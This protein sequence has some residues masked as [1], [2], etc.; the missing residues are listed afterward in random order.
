MIN[1]AIIHWGPY[2]PLSIPNDPMQE[3]RNSTQSTK[4]IRNISFPN[5]IW[6][7]FSNIVQVLLF[8]YIGR[9]IHCLTSRLP[10]DQPSDWA[11]FWIKFVSGNK[12]RSR[13]CQRTYLALC[14]LCNLS[15]KG[16]AADHQR[17]FPFPTKFSWKREEIS[18]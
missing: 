3:R 11:Y 12:F 16:P 4:L 13:V 18:K 2:E 14:T 5:L 15:K 7:F 17:S 6:F 9:F 10:N 1:S 8:I